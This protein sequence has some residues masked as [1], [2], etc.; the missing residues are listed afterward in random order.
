MIVLRWIVKRSI[1]LLLTVYVVITFT[2]FLIRLMPG[3]IIDY[4]VFTYV[5]EGTPYEDALIMVSSLIGY[6]TSAPVGAQYIDYLTNLLRGDLGFSLYY[7]RVPVIHILARALPWTAFV[8][9]IGLTT[10]FALGIA[11]GILMAYRRGGILEGTASLFATV[12]W[13]VPNYI[14][15]LLFL[16]AI[17]ESDP[18]LLLGG[19]Y[20]LKLA[21][22]F[23]WPF[24]ASVFYHAALP[25]AT[26]VITGMGSWMLRM[27][28]STVSVLGEDYV[29]AAEARGL[30]KRRV[31]LS[32]VGRNAVLPLFT[33]FTIAIG[34]MFSG[35][36]LI[37]NIFTYPG[38]GYYLGFSVTSRDYTVMQGCF[39]LITSAVVV[40]NFVADLLYSR[41]DPRI[42]LG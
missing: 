11:L 17:A 21:P 12:M 7:L 25:I 16:F 35:S 41:L 36:V 42:K 24:I 29:M 3:N 18:E 27:K 4:L 38:I 13:A 22:G 33:R 26:Y 5:M 28:G 40:A 2:F 32:Y 37:E 20:N 19:A 14:I 10:S 23:N 1:M 9:S 15:G 30:K 6:N 39:L 31:A 8:L 34:M